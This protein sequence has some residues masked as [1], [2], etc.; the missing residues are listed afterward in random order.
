M[1]GGSS[2]EKGE[3]KAEMVEWGEM[4]CNTQS[5]CMDCVVYPLGQD[6]PQISFVA[7]GDRKAEMKSKFMCVMEREENK[8]P[9][10]Q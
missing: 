10:G 1:S 3:D 8:R 7:V 6:L 2:Q 4:W 5:V 9:E